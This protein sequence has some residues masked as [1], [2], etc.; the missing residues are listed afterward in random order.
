MDGPKLGII[1]TF[2]HSRTRNGRLRHGRA[3]WSS[4]TR[5]GYNY[6]DVERLDE[7]FNVRGNTAETT[8]G[9]RRAPSI[10]VNGLFG[11]GG[12]SEDLNIYGPRGAW[13]RST[14]SNGDNILSIWW[15]L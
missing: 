12:A 6:I 1:R 8:P 11:N 2:K 3:T 4:E 9:G 7:Y 14:A 10:A 13:K 15:H 5:F